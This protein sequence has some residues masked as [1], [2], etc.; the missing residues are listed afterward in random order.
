MNH[1]VQITAM[2]HDLCHEV[3]EA[4]SK[5]LSSQAGM[6]A[7]LF[8]PCFY[9]FLAVSIFNIFKCYLVTWLVSILAHQALS[10]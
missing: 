7:G 9:A 1:S 4:E 2:C 5:C 6:D 3:R 10:H 8:H